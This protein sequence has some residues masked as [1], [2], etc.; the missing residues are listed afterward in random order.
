MNYK[1]KENCNECETAKKSK[2][3]MIPDQ[4]YTA[5]ASSTKVMSASNERKFRN[6]K[7]EENDSKNE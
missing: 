6:K 7:N 3:K 4:Q 2:L 1:A 5:A